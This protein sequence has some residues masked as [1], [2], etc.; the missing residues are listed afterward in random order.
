MAALALTYNEILPFLVLLIAVIVVRRIIQEHTKC[1]QILRSI[2]VCG[3]LSIT[4][5]STYFG[6]MLH[7]I[8]LMMNATVGWYQ[9]KNI[10]TYLAYF[11]SSV[12]ADYCFKTTALS[13]ESFILELVT[14]LAALLPI[15]GIYK[16]KKEIKLE[17]FWLT[18]PYA[19]IFLYFIFFTKDP[20]SGGIG[21]TWNIFKMM[22][23]Y[24]LVAILL[25]GIAISKYLEKRG[26]LAVVFLVVFIGLNTYNGIQYAG[27]LSHFMKDYTGVKVNPME[28]YYLLREK[29]GGNC[30][31]LVDVPQE[32]RLPLSY[33]LRDNHLVID[34]SSENVY[35]YIKGKGLDFSNDNLVILTYDCN[36]VMQ[37]AC[38][39]HDPVCKLYQCNNIITNVQGI[40]GLEENSDGRQWCWSRRQSEMTVEK[41][42]FSDTEIM[43]LNLANGS[44]ESNADLD[45]YV[46]EK[47]FNTVTLSSTQETSILIELKDKISNI[48]F[49]Y[50]GN[51]NLS[52]INDPRELA[53]IIEGVQFLENHNK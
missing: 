27:Y 53:F 26:R 29:W 17:F 43:L 6:G 32:Q 28:Q 10:E 1:F 13:P 2:L 35:S 18:V 9:D 4:L 16:L 38:E 44:K 34:C 49:D 30:I 46:N 7:A 39:D 37:L 8:F 22:Q 36:G 47:L 48:R 31:V 51:V 50:K 24:F 33:F 12:P 11:L 40:Y 45:I 41:D 5:I 21:N 25:I 52:N 15:I 14:L 3:I 42:I 20:V 19:L 23:Y